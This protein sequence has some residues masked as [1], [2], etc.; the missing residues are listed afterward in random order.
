MAGQP[1]SRQELWRAPNRQELA[2]KALPPDHPIDAVSPRPRPAQASTCLAAVCRPPIVIQASRSSSTPLPRTRPPR[3]ERAVR[4]ALRAVNQPQGEGRTRRLTLSSPVIA[5]PCSARGRSPGRRLSAKPSQ[6]RVP[7][8]GIVWTG[9]VGRCGMNYP[10]SPSPLTP[11]PR[12][13]QHPA[14]RN[15]NSYQLFW[16]ARG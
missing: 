16:G 4:I 8:V 15:Q 12:P 1:S 11:H 13:P 5:C 3:A 7:A 10:N 2:A 14:Q 9:E 6:M